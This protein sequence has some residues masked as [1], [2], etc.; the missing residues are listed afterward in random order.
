MLEIKRALLLLLVSCTLFACSKEDLPAAEGTRLQMIASKWYDTLG[1]RIFNYDNQNKLTAVIDSNNNGNKSRFTLDYDA[2]GRLLKIT[3]SYNPGSF[4]ESTSSFEYDNLD[5]IVKSFNSS[6]SNPA[7]NTSNIYSYDAKGRLVRDSFFDYR[8]NGIVSYTT[9]TYDGN[10]NVVASKQILKSGSLLRDTTQIQY[11]YDNKL[12]PLF[13]QPFLY[14]VLGDVCLNK[15]NLVQIKY[16]DGGVLNYN[17]DYHINGLPKQAS[18]K[19]NSDPST[20]YLN[21]Y[22][23]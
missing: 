8:T 1:Y 18:V 13:S 4:F 6:I 14:F 16:K 2:N 23:E 5:R 20:T 7:G 3:F 11:S 9:Y 10:D 12:N 17:Y 15:N 19:Y 21:F 22:Y